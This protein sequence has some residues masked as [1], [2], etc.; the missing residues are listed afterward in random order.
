M[1]LTVSGCIWAGSAISALDIW[2]FGKEKDRMHGV[3]RIYVASMIF[4]I[5]SATA[6][7]FLII[8]P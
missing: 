8:C 2:Y 1:L 3:L 5:V 6:H 4:I 7:F